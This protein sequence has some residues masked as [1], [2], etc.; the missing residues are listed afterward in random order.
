VYNA[1][2]DE[3]GQTTLAEYTKIANDDSAA[4]VSSSWGECESVLGASLAKAEDVVF[5]QMATQ[6][7]SMFASAGDNGAFD[8]GSTPQTL[9]V[10][11]PE[12]QPW[13]TSVGGTSWQNDNPGTN[14][15]PAYRAGVESVWNV[16]SLCNESADEGGDTGLDWCT[17]TGAGGGGSSSFW[18]R[19]WYQRGPGVNNPF[20]TVGNGTT[21]CAFAA[22]GQHCRE[23][24][25][26]SAN[27]DQY[28][29]YAEYCTG[30][31]KTANSVCA[32]FSSSQPSPGWFGIGGTSLS[33]PLWSGIAADRDSYQGHRSGNFNP[34]VYRLLQTDPG[35]YF[36]D[37]T[38]AGQ[39]TLNNGFFPTTPG[40]D[41]ATG[42]GTPRMSPLIIRKAA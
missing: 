40:Y 11:D 9:A 12:S 21:Q 31:A 20:T 13:V 8:C 36:H 32:T 19:P 24:P 1:P 14:A 25:D 27:A 29:P 26:V 10:D 35:L 6:G 33:S 5:E 16:D 41:E 15:H 18:G 34:M 7:Q 23:V 17:T 28:T 22:K 42:V 39:H 38:G 2:N 3:T 4:A 37:I 30:T